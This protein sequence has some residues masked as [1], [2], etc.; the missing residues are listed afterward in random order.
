[1][2]ADIQKNVRF[3]FTVNVLDGALFGLGM[4]FTS[5]VTVIPLF[6]SG[7]TDSSILIG[8]VAAMH[9]IGW[10]L[11]QLLTAN[12]VSRLRRYKP[13]VL[14][15][16][17]NERVPFFALALVALALPSLGKNVA[18]LLAFVL[19]TWQAMGSGLTGNAWQ[20]MIAKIMPSSLRGTFYGAQ[21]SAANLLSSG[22]AV[23]GGIILTQ[24]AAPN[25][26]ALCF[27]LTGTCM[28]VS[29]TFL[30]TTREPE[31]PPSHEVRRSR[32]EFRGALMQILRRD[33]SFRLFLGARM[34]S[35]IASIGSAFFTVFAV[36]QF[37]MDAGTAGVMTGVLMIAQTIANPI[38]GW[39]GDRYSHRLMFAVGILMAGASAA[40]AMIAPSLEWFYVVFALAGF[41][42]AGLWTTAMALTVEFGTEADRPAYIGL[43]N[44]LTAPATLVAPLLAGWLADAVSYQAMFGVAAFSGLLT[45]ALAYIMPEPR[46]RIESDLLVP[47]SP[48]VERP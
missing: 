47:A 44:T 48:Y 30:A 2:R 42:G 27:L 15:M 26:F 5:Y 43:A 17:L 25:N 35:Q 45:A 24:V 31:G 12:L 38:F 16:T 29:M 19:I 3:N 7:L 41:A 11:P 33:V 9:S 20:T 18:L 32:R 46:K 8:L 6:V 22:S 37:S 14:L 10:Q 4:G 28:M 34:L 1:M 40:I 23:L 36:R 21:S 39:L 13:L